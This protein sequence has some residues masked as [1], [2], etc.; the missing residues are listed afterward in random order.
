M[1]GRGVNGSPLSEFPAGGMGPKV[2]DA[3]PELPRF[4]PLC[5]LAPK[6]WW[7]SE[8]MELK[9]SQNP[10]VHLTA[11]VRLPLPAVTRRS[12]KARAA[13]RRLVGTSGTTVA[14]AHPAPG[15]PPP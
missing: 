7:T 10:T 14:T 12:L 6:G 2:E 13:R 8:G 15:Q 5:W 1:Q 3:V 4:S 11:M 9:I